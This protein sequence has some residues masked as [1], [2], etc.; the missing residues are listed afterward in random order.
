LI[1]YKGWGPVKQI[2]P[3]DGLQPPLISVVEAVGKVIFYKFAINKILTGWKI[4]K[5]GLSL[6]AC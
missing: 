5:I 4:A 2:T 6:Q 3:A 1:F